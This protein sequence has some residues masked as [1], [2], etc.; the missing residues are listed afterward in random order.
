[1]CSIIGFFG[2]KDAESKVK[3]GL[4]LLEHRGRDGQGIYT[5][6]YGCLGHN[7]HSIVGTLKQPIKG[8]GVFAANCEIYNWKGLKQQHNLKS[9]NDAELLF[10][11]IEGVTDDKSIDFKKIK[12]V[13]HH[14]D[15][16]YAFAYW[17]KTEN[18]NKI[19]LARDIFGVKP[20]WYSDT[21][22]LVFSSEKKA[23]EKQGI[24]DA[25]ELNP[26]QILVYDLEKKKTEFIERDFFKITPENKNKIEKIKKEVAGLLTNAV[27]KRIPDKKFGILFSGGIDSTIIALI[28]KE[29]GL[30]F[31]CYTAVL[32]EPGMSK[33][34]D[35]IHAEKIAKA[36]GL[37]LKVKK[38]RLNQVPK[39]LKTIVPLIESNNVVKVGVA[40]PFFLACEMAKKDDVKVIFSGLGSEE[41]F[42]GYD[43]HEKS[44]N[45]NK[46]CLSGLRQIYERDMYR[47]D[48][49]TMFHSIELRLPFLDKK[50][51]DYSLKIPEKHKIVGKQ[52]KVVLREASK[53]LGLQNEFADRPKKA[54]QYGSK[55]DRA[56]M[57][58]AKKQGQLKSEYL[59]TFYPTQNMRLGVLFSSGKDSS[60]AAYIM[61][62]QNYDI[63]CLI[64]IKSKNPASYMFHTPNIDVTSMQADAMGIPLV[65][66]ITEG[67]KEEEL[68]DLEKAILKAK[69]KYKLDGIITGAL[70]STYQRDRIEKICDKA[71]MK[72][73]NPLWHK[74][75]ETEM[76]ELVN[77]G[78]EVVISAIAAYGLDEKW[79]GKKIDQK[80][81]DELVKKKD[82]LGVNI[83][84][85]GGEFESLVLD[86]PMFSKKLVL[87][88][89]KKV[90][91][92]EITGVLVI[93]KIES[94]EKDKK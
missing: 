35:L 32:D 84:G 62:K 47:D 2:I 83:A 6:E 39:Y 58:L 27:S 74:D 70:F 33:A 56:I 10:H 21:N 46:E 68:K 14:L 87:K 63:K 52:K 51:V 82:K 80:A 60:Y 77:E 61:H 85:E 76:R 54:A 30:D 43:R 86:S 53:D 55:F 3:N 88:K 78:F 24:I 11:L 16:V 44:T 4:K 71:G 15:G 41:I 20:I 22:H 90:M 29:L 19:I 73:F 38:V 91:E 49:L 65:E 59:K 72:V 42:A 17:I 28:C 9:K 89:T 18:A 26:R 79:V 45:I 8:R 34:D 25:K 81:I 12:Q 40:L 75:Q 31:T 67:K 57:K 7:L 92:D 37:K 1:M 23:L 93:E 5:T 64:T 69:K 36:L 50:L 48:V 66:Q 94:K 13:L